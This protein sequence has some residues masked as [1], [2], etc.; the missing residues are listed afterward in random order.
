[1]RAWSDYNYVDATPPVLKR[2]EAIEAVCERHQ[3]PLQAAALQFS[4]GA[5]CGGR[6]YSG[7]AVSG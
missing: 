1:V 4:H 3:V 7:G 2:V 6:D 5:P